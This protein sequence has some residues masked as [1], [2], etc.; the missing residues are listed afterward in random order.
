MWNAICFVVMLPVM[1]ITLWS[2]QRLPPALLSF[3]LTAEILSGVISGVLLL[4]EPFTLWQAVGAA[5]IIFG[6]VS[7]VLPALMARAG[8]SV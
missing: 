1:F 7:E 3:L 2:A 5:L 4:N 8:R 6:A